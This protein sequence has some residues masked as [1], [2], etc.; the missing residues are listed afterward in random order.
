M[1]WN[2]K[3]KAVCAYS[4]VNYSMGWWRYYKVPAIYLGLLRISLYLQEIMYRNCI[5]GLLSCKYREI[6]NNPE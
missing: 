2:T 1:K 6:L 5:F 3:L 4:L